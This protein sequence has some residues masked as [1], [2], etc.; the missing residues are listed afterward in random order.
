MQF[1]LNQFSRNSKYVI[2]LSCE[3]VPIFLEEF[4]EHEFLFRIQIVAY[5]SNIGRLLRGQRDC[6]A[7]CILWLDGCLGGFGLGHDQV[8]VGLDQGLIQLLELCRSC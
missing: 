7:E 5:V 6:L 8:W 4:D 2:R 3:D 1:M